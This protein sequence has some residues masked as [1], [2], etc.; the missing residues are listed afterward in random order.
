MKPLKITSIL[1]SGGR[2]AWKVFTLQ[3][4]TDTELHIKKETNYLILMG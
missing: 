4:T 1:K 3:C 2:L